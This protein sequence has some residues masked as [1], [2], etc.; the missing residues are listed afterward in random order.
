MT[1]GQVVRRAM[2]Y[3][4]EGWRLA[5]VNGQREAMKERGAKRWRRILHPELSK[6]GPCAECTADAEITH[7]IED[8]FVEFH[9]NGVCSQQ[10]LEYTSGDNEMK[11]EMPVPTDEA[12]VV[13]RRRVE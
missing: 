6:D 2:M 13:R 1:K 10:F 7:D 3:P 4:E 12:N 5:V 9:P 8:D 11:I